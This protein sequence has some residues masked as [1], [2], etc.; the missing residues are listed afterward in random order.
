LEHNYK[1]KYHYS[2]KCPE[3]LFFQFKANP[4]AQNKLKPKES[5]L[6]IKIFFHKSMNKKLV[7][8]LSWETANLYGVLLE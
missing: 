1:S 4:P 8:A 5:D 2:S 6:E 7:G 3:K